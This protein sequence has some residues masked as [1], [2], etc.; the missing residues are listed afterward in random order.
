MLLSHH[1]RCRLMIQIR[2]IV[3]RIAGAVA[4]LV[5]NDA[6]RDAGQNQRSGSRLS[7]HRP[8]KQSRGASFYGSTK[9][10]PATD[11]NRY[12][13]EGA[14]APRACSK[15]CAFPLGGTF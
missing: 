11:S 10:Q 9:G 15:K 6:L 4:F 14:A 2:P 7:I 8:A 5:M 13:P 1:L 12:R 3:L